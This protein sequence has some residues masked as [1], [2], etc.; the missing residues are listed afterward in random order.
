VAYL[1]CLA[2]HAFALATTPSSTDVR[3][4]RDVPVCADGREL[5]ESGYRALPGRADA[6]EQARSERAAAALAPSGA[7]GKGTG[8]MCA[9]RVS[10][11]GL[12]TP[13]TRSAVRAV[14][15]LPEQSAAARR[16][17]SPDVFGQREI[18]KWP[19]PLG[20]V[21]PSVTHLKHDPVAAGAVGGAAVPGLAVKHETVARVPGGLHSRARPTPARSRI[22]A[23][24]GRY[25]GCP[26]QSGLGPPP[27]RRR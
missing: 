13:W 15:M 19:E 27:L 16:R 8:Q 12:V 3:E 20:N 11:V 24:G 17:R 21:A 5:A 25:D 10:R 22:W 6:S 4:C 14:R 2:A 1:A 7:A 23:A 9:Y 18:D 26:G